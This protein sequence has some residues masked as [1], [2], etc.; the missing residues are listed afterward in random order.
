MVCI[1]PT[2]RLTILVNPL[3]ENCCPGLVLVLL[4]L[5]LLLWTG[6]IFTGETSSKVVKVASVRNKTE[7]L[8]ANLS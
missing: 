7:A 6:I 8:I 1:A 5:L 2:S 4:E 3:R